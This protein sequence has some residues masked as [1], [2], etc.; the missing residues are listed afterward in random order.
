MKNVSEYFKFALM[1]L[2]VAGIADGF[3]EWRKWFDEGVMSNWRRVTGSIV[4]ISPI[5]ITD[6]FFDF[7]LF[8]SSIMWAANNSRKEHQS[9]TLREKYFPMLPIVILFTFFATLSLVIDFISADTIFGI[10]VIAFYAILI[11]A[12]AALTQVWKTVDRLLFL[13][14]LVT[15]FV[16][17]LFSVFVLTDPSDRFL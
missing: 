16:F 11:S 10:S 5:P 15:F 14:K 2:G 4:Q 8:F 7:V 12:A 6:Y 13:K 9:L 3:F 17:F 1:W